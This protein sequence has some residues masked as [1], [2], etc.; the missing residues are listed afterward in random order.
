MSQVD[1]KDLV[2]GQRGAGH[3]VL[4]LTTSIEMLI[5][6]GTSRKANASSCAVWQGPLQVLQEIK[7]PTSPYQSLYPCIYAKKSRTSENI[8]SLKQDCYLQ[9]HTVN[10]SVLHSKSSAITLTIQRS[11]RIGDI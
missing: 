6:W 7:Q 11:S 2:Q 8:E 3:I 1:H 9:F 10:C 4:R 5:C